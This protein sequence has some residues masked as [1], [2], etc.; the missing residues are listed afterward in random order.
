M[1]WLW[2]AGTTSYFEYNANYA[3]VYLDLYLSN[4]VMVSG[5]FNVDISNVYHMNANCKLSTGS[6]GWPWIAAPPSTSTYFECNASYAF[7]FIK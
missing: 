1:G 7:V 2:I 3:F 5:Y 6:V 4:K